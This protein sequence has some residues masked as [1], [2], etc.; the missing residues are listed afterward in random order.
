MADLAE[1]QA[2]LIAYKEA[3]IAIL[4]SQS[5]TYKDITYTRTDLETVTRMIKDLEIQIYG[6]QHGGT[7]RVRR[8]VPRDL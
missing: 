8:V 1:L 5:Y 6:L 3:E 7:I 4:K 2:R